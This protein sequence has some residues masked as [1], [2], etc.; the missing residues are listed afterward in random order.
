MSTRRLSP[1]NRTFLFQGSLRI[2]LHCT[3]KDT[4]LVF[5]RHA[6]S[7]LRYRRLHPYL[8]NYRPFFIYRLPYA[9]QTITAGASE[10]E[11]FERCDV[12]IGGKF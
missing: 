1:R 6:R 9:P 7:R 10:L 4:V 3:N 5:F 8:P 2:I 12:E 11:R